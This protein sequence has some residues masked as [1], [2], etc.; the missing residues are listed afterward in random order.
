MADEIVPA[1]PI[2]PPPSEAAREAPITPAGPIKEPTWTDTGIDMAKAAGAGIVRGATALAGLPGSAANLV[3]DTLDAGAI[4]LGLLSPEAKAVGD[5]LDLSKNYLS[6][7]A[8]ERGLS[9]VTEGATDYRGNTRAGRYAGTVGEFLPTALGGP[10]SLATRILTG[11]AA[12]AIGSE[13]AGDLAK[14][15]KYEPYAKIAG[16]ILG[17]IGGN[18]IEGGIRRVVSPSGGADA[19]DLAKA[20]YLRD[21]GIPVSAGQATQSGT[22]RAMEANNPALQALSAASPDSPQLQAFTSAALGMAGL[23]DDVVARVKMRPDFAGGNP[24]LAT[25]AV[26][27]ELNRAIGERFDDALTG[28]SARP[29]QQLYS[30]MQKALDDINP[31]NMPAGTAKRAVPTPLLR[32]F[33]EWNTAM[34]GGGLMNAQRLQGFRSQLGDYLSHAD[35]EIAN[36]ARAVRD[37]LD[38]AIETAVGSMGQPERMQALLAARE[39]YRN[40]LAVEKA[41]KINSEFGVNGVIRPQELASAAAQTQGKRAAVTGRGTEINRLAQTGVDMMRPL[42][43]STRSAARSLFPFG[44]MVGGGLSG[45]GL[46]QGATMLGVS[47]TV[48]ALGAMGTAGL[49]GIDAVRRIARQ[50]IENRAASPVVQR[51]LENQLMNPSTGRDALQ[52]GFLGAA[53]AYLSDNAQ[54]DGGRVERKAGGRVGVNHDKLADQLVGAAERAKKGINRGTETLLDMPDDHIAHALE[55]ANRSI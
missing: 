44:E 28:V 46:L 3:N 11:A 22:V 21:K 17:G 9:N 43:P 7:E 55:V 16:A 8:M 32:L 52:S 25:N 33:G 47:P 49:A 4:K 39:Q 45:L 48:G 54:A 5:K 31:P 41:L 35:P 51:Y 14:D 23:T 19:V 27:D 38:D 20:Q 26:M 24:R 6:G 40:Y 37:A 36:S 13:L 53:G 30:A 1:G 34:R 2:V 10:G 12:P 15:T 42:G 50:A 29:T 18:V